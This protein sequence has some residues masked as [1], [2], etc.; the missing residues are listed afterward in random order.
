VCSCS[1]MPNGI[2][3]H[4][5]EKQE[6]LEKIWGTCSPLDVFIYKANPLG[7]SICNQTNK[8]CKYL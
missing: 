4:Q 6:C 2:P 7:F 3:T 8:E 1:H 5:H